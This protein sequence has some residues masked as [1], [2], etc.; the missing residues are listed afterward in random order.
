MGTTNPQR[1]EE[2]ITFHGITES[3]LKTKPEKKLW[4]DYIWEKRLKDGAGS[5]AINATNLSIHYRKKYEDLMVSTPPPAPPNELVAGAPAISKVAV[6]ALL[7][8]LSLLAWS[9]L[10]VAYCELLVSH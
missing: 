7:V 3:S 1:S 6:H 10:W 5:I 4:E 2:V 9:G 8:V